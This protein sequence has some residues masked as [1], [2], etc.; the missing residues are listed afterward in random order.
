[1][2]NDR[3]EWDDEKARVNLAKHQLS[4]ETVC[5]VFDDPNALDDPDDREDYEEER[6]NRTGMVNGLLVT[7]TYTER[8]DRYRIIS[9][10]RATRREQENYF[11]R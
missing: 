2:Q 9:A 11:E 3:F 5:A 1:M 10:R 4:F 8:E 7:V 6:S